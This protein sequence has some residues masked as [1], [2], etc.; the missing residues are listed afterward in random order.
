MEISLS[1]FLVL[2]ISVFLCPFM[3]SSRH[4]SSFLFSHSS[5]GSNSTKCLLC[6]YLLL[7]ISLTLISSRLSCRLCPSPTPLVSALSEKT[8]R[9]EGN[10][11]GRGSR[12]GQGQGGEKESGSNRIRSR[13]GGRRLRSD[14]EA[15]K[16]SSEMQMELGGYMIGH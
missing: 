4:F 15:G 3:L 8:T 5:A 10:K 13:K 1:L 2:S 16:G 6:L 11:R 14:E 12:G 7:P 9:G